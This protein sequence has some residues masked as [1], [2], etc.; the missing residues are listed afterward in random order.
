M[1]LVNHGGDICWLPIDPLLQ[2]GHQFS[3]FPALGD[4]RADVDL[5]AV[6]NNGVAQ[7]VLLNWFDHSTG[8]QPTH[9][10]C[11][12]IVR[13]PEVGNHDVPAALEK[14]QHALVNDPTEDLVSHL[15]ITRGHCWIKSG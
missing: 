7:G 10:N 9:A 6:I 1:P 11:V 5:I 8:T 13:W 2:L 12:L 4:Y 3:Q 15:R 14:V